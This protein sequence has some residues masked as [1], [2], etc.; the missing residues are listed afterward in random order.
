MTYHLNSERVY[1]LTP[2]A[3]WCAVSEDIMPVRES[4]LHYARGETLLLLGRVSDSIWDIH[5]ATSLDQWRRLESIPNC[6]H[7]R[8]SLQS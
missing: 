3:V 1:S 6:S 8:N 2:P 7:A 4:T 5:S